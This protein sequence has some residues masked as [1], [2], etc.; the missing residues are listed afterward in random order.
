MQV[1]E[2]GYDTENPF[3]ETFTTNDVGGFEAP[4]SIHIFF[5]DNLYF[6]ISVGGTGNFES[7]YDGIHV[8][9]SL[10]EN[11]SV[12]NIPTQPIPIHLIFTLVGKLGVTDTPELPA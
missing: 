11:Y 8:T 7:N 6:D 1:G 3:R 10:A 12:E 5:C 4:D 2:S 9:Y